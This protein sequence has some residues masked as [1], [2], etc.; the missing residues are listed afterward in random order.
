MFSKSLPYFE[1]KRFLP[2][3]VRRYF[4]IHRAA[5]VKKTNKPKKKINLTKDIKICSRSS[6]YK[7][8][9]HLFVCIF[10]FLKRRKCL[11]ESTLSVM[12]KTL[13]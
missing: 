8:V 2:S 13:I 12:M 3:F 5:C 4:H 6:L 7:G 11:F 1:E 9:S 10:A